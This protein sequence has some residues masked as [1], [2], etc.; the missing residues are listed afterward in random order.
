MDCSYSIHDVF[1]QMLL[2]MII[3]I[4]I[5]SLYRIP[6]DANLQLI[7]AVCSIFMLIKNDI[8]VRF[9]TMKLKYIWG[10]YTENSSLLTYSIGISYI[11]VQLP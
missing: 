10:C 5:I 1:C 7:A 8:I 11:Y 4:P 9:M 3:I 2:L 6:A